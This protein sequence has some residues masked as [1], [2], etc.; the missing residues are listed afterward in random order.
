MYAFPVH[1]QV[2]WQLP[3][4]PPP[5]HY[6]LLHALVEADG[7]LRIP[8]VC[9]SMDAGF[10]VGRDARGA[11][12]ELSAHRA[13]QNTHMQ[14]IPPPPEVG[15]SWETNPDISHLGGTELDEMLEGFLGNIGHQN[16]V[17]SEP[18]SQALCLESQAAILK[19]DIL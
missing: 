12:K 14:Q 1:P 4:C 9:G 17:L 13:T 19:N 11:E 2:G 18:I 10:Q 3:I 7:G 8:T 16:S 5:L 15:P 6:D